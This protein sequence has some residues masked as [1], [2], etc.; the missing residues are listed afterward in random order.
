MMDS[1]AFHL[2]AAGIFLVPALV[3]GVLAHG[4]WGFM[5]S[6]RTRPTLKPFVALTF[7]AT[8]LVALNV[9]IT[10]LLQLLP[11][12]LREQ[13]GPLRTFTKSTAVAVGTPAGAAGGGAVLDAIGV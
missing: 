7:A 5:R 6:V 4:L 8:S 13:P 11:P 12:A 2:T 10:V 9:S 3:W 1:Q